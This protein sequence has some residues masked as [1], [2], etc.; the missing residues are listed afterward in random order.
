MTARLE[1]DRGDGFAPAGRHALT[2]AGPA[3]GCSSYPSAAG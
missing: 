3:G 1:L 2:A